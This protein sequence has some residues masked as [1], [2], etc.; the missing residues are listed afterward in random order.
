MNQKLSDFKIPLRV[1]SN[2]RIYKIF[3]FVVTL[4]ICI[5][6]AD[7][8]F[9]D[10][11]EISK[12]ILFLGV[13]SLLGYSIY[14]NWNVADVKIDQEYFYL[15][16]SRTTQKFQL[17]SLKSLKMLPDQFGRK[18]FWMLEYSDNGNPKS[19]KFLQRGYNF[20]FTD[21]IYQTAEE[22]NN[23]IKYKKYTYTFDNDV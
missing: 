9:N 23:I 15:S 21:L 17:K 12:V 13:I 22:N 4:G 10:E 19:V 6:F 8:L 14:S 16:F 20:K 18:N 1:S 3:T 5:G 7:Y 2:V 11:I